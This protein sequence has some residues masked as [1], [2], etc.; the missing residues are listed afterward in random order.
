MFWPD[1]IFQSVEQA[2]RL[3][4]G[5]GM[6]PWEFVDGARSWIFPGALAIVL[7]LGSFFASTAF[8]LMVMARLSMVAVGLAGL[9]ASMQLGRRLAGDGK[10]SR[11][12]MLLAGALGAALPPLLV[13]GAKCMSEMAS[14]A[15]I[16]WVAYLATFGERRRLWASGA[17]AAL[18]IYLRYQNGVVAVGLLI[19]ILSARRW[20][21]ARWFA[22]AAALVGLAGGFLD[23]FTWGRPFHSFIRYVQFN[24]IEGRAAAWGQ[25]PPIYYLDALWSSIGPGVLV[26]AA[27]LLL[28][29]RKAWALVALI[30]VYI[31]AH[32]AVPHKELRFL[33]PVMPLALSLAAAGLAPAMKKIGGWSAP[34]LSAL[35]VWSFVDKASTITFEQ[36]GQPR[37]LGNEFSYGASPWRA[38]EGVNR[39]LMEASTRAD[40]C[41]L[42]VDDIHPAVTGG[43]A[44]LHR[45]V[46]MMFYWPWATGAANYRIARERP[47]RAPATRAC[48]CPRATCWSVATGRARRRRPT[49]TGESAE[50][51]GSVADRSFRGGAARPRRLVALGLAARASASLRAA[52]AALLVGRNSRRHRT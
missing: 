34:L 52:G 3:A 21:E 31:A 30:I 14:G 45:D 22:E 49:S 18:S 23:L 17:L 32:S 43:Y 8:P 2:H 44:Y 20:R 24:L 7:K 29:L 51:A 16:V 40:L 38:G 46:P 37:G 36:M 6:L 5:Y 48:S 13:F 25:A 28:A 39:V 11:D 33:L 50:V 12:A 4:F 9:W 26:I 47:A 1:E 27:G 15:L 10:W 35:L 42:L 41:G 19:W